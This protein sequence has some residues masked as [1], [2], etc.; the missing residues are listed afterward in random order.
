MN[1]QFRRADKENKEELHNIALIDSKIPLEF[2]TE[3]QWS[4]KSLDVTLSRYNKHLLENDFF[5]VALS[6]DKVVGF[7]I[8]KKVPYPPDTYA[9]AIFTLWTDP[10]FRGNGIATELKKRGEVW[11]KLEGCS[12]MVTNVHLN[13]TQMLNLNKIFGF[14]IVQ[15]AMRK[16]L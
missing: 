3:F 15:H 12:L 9:G 13:N 7:H 8:V 5:E 14:G 16:K 10:K 6:D 2:D 11:A 4:E 1:I